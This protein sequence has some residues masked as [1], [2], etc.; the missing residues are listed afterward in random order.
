VNEAGRES[1]IRASECAGFVQLSRSDVVRAVG[2]WSCN[3]PATRA[4]AVN[5]NSFHNEEETQVGV[6]IGRHHSDAARVNRRE[7]KDGASE[8]QP[9]LWPLERPSFVV[10][11]VCDSRTAALGNQILIIR[12]HTLQRASLNSGRPPNALGSKIS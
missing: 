12:R 6:A 3:D 5:Q 2:V 7:P 8:R 11:Q 10:Q 4:T 9:W 1:R